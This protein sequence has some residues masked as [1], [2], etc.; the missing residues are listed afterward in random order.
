MEAVPWFSHIWPAHWNRGLHYSF[1]MYN[2][3][4]Q[5]TMET[6]NVSVCMCVHSCDTKRKQTVEKYEWDTG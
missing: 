2:A 1:T 5:K 3:N 6:T 4:I